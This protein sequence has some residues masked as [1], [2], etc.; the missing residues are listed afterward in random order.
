[1]Y[2]YQV[3]RATGDDSWLWAGAS[4][5]ESLAKHT[6]TSCGHATVKNVATLELEDTMPSF[7]LA[8]TAKYDNAHTHI[9]LF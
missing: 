6:G 9:T 1:M 7:F 5:L 3:R 2:L 4:F 8:E